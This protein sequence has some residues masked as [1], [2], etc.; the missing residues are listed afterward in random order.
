MKFLIRE[1][2]TELNY[3]KLSDLLSQSPVFFVDTVTLLGLH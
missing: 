1:E 2:G 3:C